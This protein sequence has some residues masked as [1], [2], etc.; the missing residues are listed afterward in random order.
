[1]EQVTRRPGLQPRLAAAVDVAE[2]LAQ[3]GD[4]D[5]QYPVRRGRGLVAEQLV[6]QVIAGNDLV[7]VA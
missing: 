4:P 6:D 3:P 1:V 7:S 2:R 5:P